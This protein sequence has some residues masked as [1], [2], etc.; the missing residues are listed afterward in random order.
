[1]NMSITNI[2]CFKLDGEMTIQFQ[3]SSPATAPPAD[4]GP[5]P[6][7][8][9]QDPP[10]QDD[11]P[12]PN[13]QLVR[14]ETLEAVQGLVTRR[15]Q[16]KAGRAQDDHDEVNKRAYDELQHV[17]ERLARLEEGQTRKTNSDQ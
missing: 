5:P 10:R 7:P 4:G 1:M 3:P 8:G 13:D 16:V 15:L 14:Q 17:E 2:A 11:A 12:A 9:G 6:P